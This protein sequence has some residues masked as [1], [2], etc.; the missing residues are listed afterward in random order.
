VDIIS[1]TDFQQHVGRYQDRAMN[2]PVIVTRNGQEQVV[3]L[4][5][6]EFHRLKQ[7]DRQTLSSGDLSDED[8]AWIAASESPPEAAAFDHELSE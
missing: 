7:L 4:S 2:E 6:V 3:L 8:L 1:S 5:A